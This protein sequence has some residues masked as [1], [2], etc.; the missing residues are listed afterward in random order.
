MIAVFLAVTPNGQMAI[1]NLGNAENSAIFEGIR[2]DWEISTENI[3]LHCIDGKP[4]ELGR[5]GFGTVLYASVYREDAAL[6]IIN[7]KSQ[8]F[9]FVFILVSP[10]NKQH[11][12]C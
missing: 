7:D 4:I 5:G 12:L 8:S 1:Q 2:A 11:H 9:P 10:S 6:K 3:K